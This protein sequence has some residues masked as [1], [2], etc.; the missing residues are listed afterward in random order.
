MAFFTEDTNMSKYDLGEEDLSLPL[1]PEMLRRIKNKE[2]TAD[3][4]Q[5]LRSPVEHQPQPKQVRIIDKPTRTAAGVIPAPGYCP[6]SAGVAYKPKRARLPAPKK[7]YHRGR[8]LEPRVDFPPPGQPTYNDPN[9]YPWRCVCK[10]IDP[11]GAEG[12]AALCGPRH[13]LTASHCV[14]WSTSSAERIRVH[15]AGDFFLAEAFTA[16]ALAYT[17]I[18]GDSASS[19]LLD[20]DYAVLVINERL[21]DRFGWLGTMEYDSGWDGEAFFNTMGYPVNSTFPTFQQGQWLDEDAWDFGSGRAMT[22]S[23]D[24]VSGHS[25]SPMFVTMTDGTFAAAVMTSDDPGENENWCAGGSDLVSLVN[26]ARSEH[27]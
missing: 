3:V 4:P 15:L 25:G 6:P 19:N 7:I 16:V 26:F 20:E 17:Q 10:I 11:F 13:I 18:E 5:L 23:A 22:T 8:R 27:P 9:S 21:G 12:S 1:S 14:A 2:P 24:V